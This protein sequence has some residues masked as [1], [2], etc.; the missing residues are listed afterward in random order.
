MDRPIHL[1]IDGVDLSIGGLKILNEISV[2]IY[3]G[4]LIAI[5]GPNGAGKTSLLNCISGIYNP[6]Q[7]RILFNGQDLSKLRSHEI[8]Q[9]GLAR[10]FQ[11]SELFRHMSVLENLLAGR[12]TKMKCGLLANGLFWGKTI[13]EEIAHREAVERIIAQ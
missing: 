1:S 2:N 8:A 13:K 10:T 9:M 3:K 5:I 12:H 4:D 7:G 11:L 6:T